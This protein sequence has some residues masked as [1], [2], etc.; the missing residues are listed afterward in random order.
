VRLYLDSNIFIHA[1][2]CET[3]LGHAA[4]RA[5]KL[6]DAGK[7][8]GVTSQLTLSEVLPRPYEEANLALEQAYERVFSGRRG[9]EVYP[10]SIDILRLTARLRAQTKA[11]TADAIHVAT[12][13]QAACDSLVSEDT[14]IRPP[15]HV[16][17]LRLSDELFA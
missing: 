12:A 6:A 14:R 5:F 9:L 2:E 1:F 7:I 10:V 4:R 16:R 8:I 13:M 15:S 11:R 17:L 3:E